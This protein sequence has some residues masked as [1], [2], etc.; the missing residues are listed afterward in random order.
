MRPDGVA[1]MST[2]AE[3]SDHP[4]KEVID[5]VLTTYGYTPPS[6]Y[7][8]A[9]QAIIPLTASADTLDRTARTAG[10]GTVEVR[11]IEVDTGL[12]TATAPRAG[13]SAWRRRARSSRPCRSPSS[14]ASASGGEGRSAPTRHRSS[15]G[16]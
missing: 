11:D 14:R 7:T 6:W 5:A 9:K 2:F 4:S 16:C 3:G 1:L 8:E 12:R 13:G 10:F 15:L